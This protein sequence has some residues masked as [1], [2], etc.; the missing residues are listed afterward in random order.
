MSIATGSNVCAR[1]LMALVCIVAIHLAANYTLIGQFGL[2]E[3]DW[4]FLG[5]RLRRTTSD[6][7][8]HWRRCNNAARQANTV[9]LYA[10]WRNDIVADPV[11]HRTIFLDRTCHGPR[12]FISG[13]VSCF[14]GSASG[15]RC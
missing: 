7:D 5:P 14:R 6:C 15:T 10:S 13:I 8:R 2:Y 11:R 1:H 9:C 12:L 4:L 3:D